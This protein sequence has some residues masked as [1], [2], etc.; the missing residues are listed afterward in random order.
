[1]NGIVERADREQPLA[2]ERMRQAERGEHQEEV[3]LG[4]AELEVLALRRNVPG[5]GRGD[6][7]ALED[8]GQRLAAEQAAA[9][10]ERAEIGGD[11]HVRRGRDDAVGER[12]FLARQLVQDL[13]EALLGRG[14]RLSREGEGVRERD[15]APR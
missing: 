4:D 14:D 10:H 3:V 12:R 13:P 5:E 15:T 6:A 11:G 7:L 9:V 1:M 8:V 2:E